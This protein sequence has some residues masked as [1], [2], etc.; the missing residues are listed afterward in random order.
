MIACPLE[1][2]IPL[3][4]AVVEE[5]TGVLRHDLRNKL[6]SIRNSLFYIRKRTE[7]MTTLLTDDPRAAQFFQLIESELE[8]C[9]SLMVAKHPQAAK[10]QA[11]K[12]DLPLRCMNFLKTLTL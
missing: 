11:E 8:A 2:Q 12:G 10:G 3:R 1:L 9:N 5:A 4:A 7:K 6:A